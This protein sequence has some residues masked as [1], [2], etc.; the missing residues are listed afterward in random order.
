MK[1][2]DVMS[3][4]K[5]YTV[6]HL[7]IA[8]SSVDEDRRREVVDK[9]YRPLFRLARKHDLPLGIEATGFTLE[10][11][12]SIDQTLVDELRLLTGKGPCEFVGS[13]YAQIIGPLVP[14]EVNAANL[15]IG[16]EVYGDLLGIQPGIALVNEQAYSAGLVRHYLDNG[17][18]GIVMEWDNPS[19]FHPDWDPEW[20]Y[21]P[22]VA[23]GLQG[24]E[25]P[26]LWNRSIAFQKFQRYAHGETELDEYLGY[27]ASHQSGDGRAMSLYGNDVEI[28]DFRPGR[29]HTEAILGKENEWD[30]I[31]KLFDV[32]SADTRF[33][34]ISP[35]EALDMLHVPAAGNRISLESSESPVPVKKQGKYNITRWA[36]T[37]RDDLGINTACWR[38]FEI[39]KGSEQA[40]EK[41]WKELCYLWSSDFRTHITEKRWEDFRTRLHDMEARVCGAVPTSRMPGN[42]PVRPLPDA[43]RKE[44]VRRERH[45]LSVETDDI[46][47]QLNCRRGLAFEA[48]RFSQCGRTS[49]C[50]TLP[51]GYF[52]DIGWGADFYTGHLVLES[53]GRPKVTDLNPVEPEVGRL[54][55]SIVI[56]GSVQTAL[57]PVYKEII[58]HLDVPRVDLEYRL[59]WSSRP[60][61]S[62]RLGHI[63]LNPEALDYD[64]LFYST[65]NGGIREEKFS[66]HGAD[67]DHGRA[68]SFLVSASG[69]IG[70]TGGLLRIGD[71]ERHLRIDVD[72][73]ASAAIGLVTC[74]RVGETYFGRVSF[75]LSEMDDTA[76]PDSG[77]GPAEPLS[78]RMSISPGG[79]ISSP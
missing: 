66:M 24:E 16:N 70:V 62:L 45:L 58:V 13:G 28:F 33:R 67:V 57:G 31:E 65:H 23:C 39:L 26:L 60:I 6:F 44:K 11:V 46:Y 37:G 68:I 20:R 2:L 51:H 71:G 48:L 76:K 9:C 75:S 29:F 36:V 42:G 4:L 10:T 78:F 63:A 32:L 61:G 27:L 52:D 54:E 1:S 53:P 50:G 25:I 12:R 15:R 74:H 7:N 59:D 79:V 40:S 18:R 3:P 43:V 35:G 22:Q 64:S 47:L 72:K 30:R 41:D 69:G 34:L 21:H 56:R 77:D 14:A 49:L 73:T 5:I 19:R 55:S 17:Y 8:Y 38:I